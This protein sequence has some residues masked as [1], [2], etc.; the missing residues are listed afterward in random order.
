MDE[1]KDQNNIDEEELNKAALENKLSEE[2]QNEAGYHFP[3][4][5][6]KIP[7]H[8]GIWNYQRPYMHQAYLS[9]PR[10]MRFSG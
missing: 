8:W 1:N 3:L 9:N 10:M 2:D 6:W 4:G 7:P 5:G